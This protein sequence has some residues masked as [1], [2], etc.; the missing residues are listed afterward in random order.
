MFSWTDNYL[1]DEPY[2]VVLEEFENGTRDEKDPLV[3]AAKIAK[4]YVDKVMSSARR[5]KAGEV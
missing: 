2:E 5:H 4:E 1:I 3:Q